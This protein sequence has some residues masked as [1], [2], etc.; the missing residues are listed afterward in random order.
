MK[1]TT[2][3]Q[4]QRTRAE[5]EEA[6]NSKQEVEGFLKVAMSELSPEG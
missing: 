2:N 6:R 4:D 1:D 3:E 5:G